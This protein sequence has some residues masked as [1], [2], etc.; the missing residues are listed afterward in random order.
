VVGSCTEAT[1]DFPFLHTAFVST[2]GS[3]EMGSV[4]GAEQPEEG[5]DGLA[6][7]W[8]PKFHVGLQRHVLGF[9]LCTLSMES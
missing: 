8:C 1:C 6:R 7:G 9:E 5:S 2:R 4:S 3:G